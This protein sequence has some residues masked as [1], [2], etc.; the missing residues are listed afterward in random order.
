MIFEF[1]SDLSSCDAKTE[2]DR[3]KGL[4]KSCTSKFGECKQAQDA[5]V[6]LT[7]TC[8]PSATSSPTMTTVSSRR[9]IVVDFLANHVV[10]KR[11]H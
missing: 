9:R 6:E 2:M 7:A 8:P 4:K 5:A 11:G 1:R 10:V 3:V